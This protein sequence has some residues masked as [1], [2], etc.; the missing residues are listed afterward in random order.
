MINPNSN[1]W[2]CS[3]CERYFSKKNQFHSCELYSIQNHHLKKATPDTIQLY[4]TLI[5][6]I[7]KFGPID[8]EPLKSIIAI[9]RNSQ[10][11][12]IQ[13]QKNA[14]KL[15]FRLFSTFSSSRFSATSQQ[16]D[17]RNYYQL[18]IEQGQDIN[19][20]LIDWLQQAYDEK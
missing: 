1:R 5:N 7:K 15:K 12:S 2:Q 17:R 8:I 6:Q 16:P 14:L 20:E 3:I 10:F 19:S 13:I 9:K 4:N 18:K 11:C